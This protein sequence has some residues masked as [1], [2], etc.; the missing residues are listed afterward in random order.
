M[1]TTCPRLL[2]GS[3][4]A[5]HWTMDLSVSYPT[6]VFNRPKF[7][8]SHDFQAEEFGRQCTKS[9]SHA[10][11]LQENSSKNLMQN[12]TYYICVAYAPPTW[13]IGF[14]C[15]RALLWHD[16]CLSVSL[17]ISLS[18]TDVLWLN[19]ARWGLRCYWLLIGSRISVF[20]WHEN[21]WPW[22]TL[23]GHNALQ[24]ANRA[25]LWLNGKS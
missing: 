16:C 19:G 24:Y 6:R 2:L 13:V 11:G 4:L 21:H 14:T 12:N 17:S 3:A 8:G 23:K 7:L 25:V 5:G 1:R 15:Y 18:V 22:M 20:K 10:V 9:G